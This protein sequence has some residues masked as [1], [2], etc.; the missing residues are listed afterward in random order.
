MVHFLHVLEE[1]L[2]ASRSFAASTND[3]VANSQKAML[4]KKFRCAE[5]SSDA[6][7]GVQVCRLTFA[8]LASTRA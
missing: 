4:S 3:N 2:A 5:Q 1:L 6:Q 8:T 7:D